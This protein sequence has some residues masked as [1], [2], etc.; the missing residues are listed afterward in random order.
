MCWPVTVLSCRAGHQLETV[1]E[2]RPIPRARTVLKSRAWVLKTQSVSHT[3]PGVMRLELMSGSGSWRGSWLKSG[4]SW[5]F[6]PPLLSSFKRFRV[7]TQTDTG[8][9]SNVKVRTWNLLWEKSLKS[10]KALARI[11][12]QIERPQALYNSDYFRHLI[13]IQ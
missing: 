9:S 5:A 10:N 3:S 13:L 8:R 1:L 7:I 12:A 2:T 4:L 11:Y 6:L